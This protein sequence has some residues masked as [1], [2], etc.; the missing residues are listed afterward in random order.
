MSER[1]DLYKKAGELAFG[2]LWQSAAAEHHGVSV[3][4]VQRWVAGN[5]TVPAGAFEELFTELHTRMAEIETHLLMMVEHLP[6][7]DGPM[8]QSG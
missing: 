7:L 4:T 5:Q 1:L 3:R 8:P 2:T 6:T